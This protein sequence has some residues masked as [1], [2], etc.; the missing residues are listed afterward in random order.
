[1]IA[2]MV[3]A[4]I[5]AAFSIGAAVAPGWYHVSADFS[6]SQQ[7]LSFTGSM[8]LDLG[9]FR[10]CMT[11]DLLGHK[12]SNCTTIK[13]AT[14]NDEDADANAC[15]ALNPA[16]TKHVTNKSM[17]HM[18]YAARG[19]AILAGVLL[20]LQALCCYLT[21]RKRAFAKAAVTFGILAMIFSIIS[22]A[23]FYHMWNACA[24]ICQTMREMSQAGNTGSGSTGDLEYDNWSCKP[25]YSLGLAILSWF[26]AIFAGT[27]AVLW[28]R[29]SDAAADG[30][31]DKLVDGRYGNAGV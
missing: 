20:V 16:T 3:L 4:I 8:T 6:A 11:L 29:S 7:G 12:Q 22:M 30:H 21:M 27:L 19:T 5:A 2:A 25:F 26:G 15:A 1:M 28:A 14:D 10:S 13:L 23:V 18:L 24:P 17:N 9:M 31:Y